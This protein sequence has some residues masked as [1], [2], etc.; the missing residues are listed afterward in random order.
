MLFAASGI[1][2]YAQ[3]EPAIT[4]AAKVEGKPLTLAFA[5]SEAG[6]KFKIDWGDG[7]PVETEEIPVDD[8]WTTVEVKGTPLGEGKI[9]IYG[10]KLAVFDCSYKA[11]DGTKLTALDVT[12]A[13]D[14]TKLTCNTHEIGTLDVSQNPDLVELVCGNNPITSLNLSANAKLAT[15]DGTNMS[16]TGID[17]TSCPALTRLMLNDNRIET[18]DLSACTGLST[19]NINNNLLESIDLSRNTEVATVNI[20]SNRLKTLDLSMCGKLS[21]VFCNGNEITSLKVGNVKTRLNCSDNRLSLAG[22]PSPGSKFFVYAP[23]K[24]M[25]LTRRVWTGEAVDL[26]AQDNLKG[27]ADEVQKTTYAWKTGDEVLAEGTDYSAENGVFTFLKAFD[28]PV[29][30]EMTTAAFPDFAGDNAFRTDSATVETEPGLY[31]ELTAEVDG[32]ERNL[33]FASATEAN[34]VIV[35]WGDGNRV[36]TD[37]IVLADEYGSTTTVTGTPAGGGDIKIYAREISVFG[38]DSRVDGAHVTAVNTSAATDLKELDVYTNAIE[39]LDLSQNAELEKLNCY[40]NNLK[41]L[42]LT[43]NK[44][45]TRLDAKDTPLAK[46]DLTRNAELEYLSLNNCPIEDI[47]LSNNKKLSSLYLLNCKLSAIDLGANAA[48][49]YVNLNNNLLA[50]LDVSACE[51]LGT[52]FCMGNQLTELKADNVTKSVNCSKNNFTLA[53]LPAL[54]CSTYTYAPQNDMPIAA[55]VKAGET[56]DLSAQNH[57]TGLA[58]SPQTTAYTWMTEDGTALAAGTDYT[59]E[60]GVFTFLTE[61]VSPV[62]CEMT[63]EAFPKFSGSNAFKTTATLVEGANSVEGARSD[64]PAVTATRGNV[65]ITGLENGAEVKVYDLSGQAVAAR[66]ATGGS[67]SF[68]VEPGLYIVKAGRISCKVNAR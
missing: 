34:R 64:A 57:V 62:H 41:D 30:C 28:K 51:A 43:A 52:L 16:L 21:V 46:I 53:T 61:Q 35:D 3:S 60:D 67:A 54:P 38:C 7:N 39:K 40:N 8:G 68:R 63:T 32:N 29:C 20:Q 26:S 19:L 23:Q 15:L 2:A 11:D 45:L 44:K 22:L 49:T 6:H 25:P 9:S 33:T 59:E 37:T 48:L 36:T 31:L 1:A 65:L 14:L 17:V 47:D 4:L 24:A 27:L 5:A 66:A 50:S 13:P 42:D 55:E 56:V 10:E 18:I 12:K 58:E